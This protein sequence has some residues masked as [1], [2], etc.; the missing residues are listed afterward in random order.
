MLKHEL[1]SLELEHH[2]KPFITKEFRLIFDSDLAN[3]ET[4]EDLFH[5]EYFAILVI[6]NSDK[7]NHFTVLINHDEGEIEFFDSL[8]HNNKLL[9]DYKK[10]NPWLKKLVVNKKQLQDKDAISCGIWCISRVQALNTDLKNYQKLW[11]KSTA[12]NEK[13]LYYTYSIFDLIGR[14]Q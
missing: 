13:R 1:S 11:K 5:D 2:L 7:S 8:A 10:K 12:D 14:N 6:Q 3:L 4:Q 9:L